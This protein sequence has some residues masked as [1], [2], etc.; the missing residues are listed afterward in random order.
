MRIYSYQEENL[1][2]SV[3]TPQELQVRMNFSNETTIRVLGLSGKKE[4]FLWWDSKFLAKANYRGYM[5]IVKGTA[6][7]PDQ[8]DYVLAVALD[9]ET[10][11]SKKIEDTYELN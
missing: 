5:D 11:A 4:D 1:F 3:E 8:A 9:L 2:L 10:P 6:T 7:V